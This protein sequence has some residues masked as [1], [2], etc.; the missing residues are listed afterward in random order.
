MMKRSIAMSIAAFESSAVEK[1][2]PPSLTT[3]GLFPAITCAAVKTNFSLMIEPA[4]LKSIF[5]SSSFQPIAVHRIVTI[6]SILWFF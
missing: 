4:A 5:P 1:S 3:V 2:K 6:R